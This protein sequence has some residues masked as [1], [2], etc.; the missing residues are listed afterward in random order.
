M[1]QDVKISAFDVAG[2]GAA[3]AIGATAPASTAATRAG[4]AGFSEHP[5]MLD[6]RGDPIV[7]AIAPYIPIDIAGADRLLALALSAAAESMA[8]M[9]ENHN[10]LSCPAIIGFPQVRPGMSTEIAEEFKRRFPK[11]IPGKLKISEVTVIPA[12]HSA[13]LMALEAGRRII[14]SGNADSCLIGGVDSYLDPDTLEWLDGNEQLHSGI[15]AWGFIPG[16]AAGFCFLVS[17][18]FLERH[19]L[20]SLCRI[21]SIGTSREKNLIK[22]DTVCIGE[23]L[24]KACRQALQHLPVEAR[25]DNIICDMNGETYRADEYGFTM[26]R[27]SERFVD[28]ANFQTPADCWGDVGAASGPLFITLAAFAGMKGYAPGPH[29]LVWNSSESGDRAAA[30]IHAENIPKE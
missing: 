16:E 12:G 30:I 3:T 19:K 7:M 11:E 29:T 18:R 27:V 23:G 13:G 14:L 24:T 15:N 21:L 17:R 20:K 1:P 10:R 22:T 9:A 25:I 5:Y 2:V 4:I 6:Q 8:S 26:A 28:P